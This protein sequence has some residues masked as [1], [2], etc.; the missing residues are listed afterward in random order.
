MD[1]AEALA[2]EGFDEVC[3]A[4]GLN[5]VTVGDQHDGLRAVIGDG[6]FGGWRGL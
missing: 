3:E 2:H 4:R 5:A 6:V 1:I